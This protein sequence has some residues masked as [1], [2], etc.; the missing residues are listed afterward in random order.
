MENQTKKSVQKIQLNSP[1]L[2]YDTNAETAQCIFVSCAHGM[3]I[4]VDHML[5]HKA[6]LNKY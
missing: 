2:T 3:Y 1:Q 5:E 4:G 6:S